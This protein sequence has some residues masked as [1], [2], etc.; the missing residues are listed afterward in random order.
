MTKV[1]WINGSI[2]PPELGEY[3]TICEYKRYFGK[4]VKNDGN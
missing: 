4:E 2:E 1:T 3:Y